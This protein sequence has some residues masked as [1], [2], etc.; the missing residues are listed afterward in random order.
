M[1]QI[2]PGTGEQLALNQ[3]ATN[4]S[5]TTWGIAYSPHYNEIIVFRNGVMLQEG[6]G[7]DYLSLGSSIVFNTG[8]IPSSEEKIMCIYKL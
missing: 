6:I 5:S 8:Q 1:L 7:N 4:L 2:F 3:V